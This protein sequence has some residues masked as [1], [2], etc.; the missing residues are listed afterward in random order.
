MSYG[1]LVSSNHFS[2][3]S[4]TPNVTTSTRPP[5]AA[6]AAYKERLKVHS[7]TTRN[8]SLMIHVCVQNGRQSWNTRQRHTCCSWMSATWSRHGSQAKCRSNT[9]TCDSDPTY[10]FKVTSVSLRTSL[11]VKF[12]G[13]SS[14]TATLTLWICPLIFWSNPWR[15]SSHSFYR[16]K[17]KTD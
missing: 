9:R 13:A 2:A 1:N 4:L 8:I 11:K 14:P 15:K 7:D 12:T 5:A 17:G 10:F 16:R 3:P 6:K